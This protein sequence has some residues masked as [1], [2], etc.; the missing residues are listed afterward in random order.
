MRNSAS[1]IAVFDSGLGGISVL[2][3]LRALMPFENYIYFGDCINAPYGEKSIDEICR[4]TTMHA[5]R[6]LF[7]A[8]A[9]AI[10]IACNTATAA[11]AA[12][13]RHKY[14]GE[15]IIGI[16]PALKPAAIAKEHP[17]VL[18]MATP[19]TL[20]ANKLMHLIERFDDRASIHLL[21]A[22]EIVRLVEAGE[23]DSA[24]ML[25]YLQDILTPYRMIDGGIQ[26]PVDCVV[27]GCTHFPFAS[28]RIQQ[29]LGYEVM[30]FDGS[31]G[32][33]RETKRRL[34][35]RNLLNPTDIPGHIA[36]TTSSPNAERAVKLAWKLLET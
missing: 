4:L 28:N 7:E 31:T 3:A 25:A 22:P 20:H 6:L 27:L 2:R 19:L 5:E 26:I 16:E 36:I 24:S 11:A 18:V 32:T 34:H 17:S 12:H 30:L 29:A 23:H 8:G 33:A 21:P 9:K 10:V 15:I 35:D 1:P 14:P 13:L